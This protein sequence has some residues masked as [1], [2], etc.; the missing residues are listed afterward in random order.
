MNTIKSLIEISRKYGSNPEFVLGGGGN[1]SC[2]DNG[3]L[4][5]KASGFALGTID[6]NGFV[7]LDLKQVLA[8]LE[9][10][11]ST[12]PAQREKQIL[13][14]LQDARLQGKHFGQV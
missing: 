14:A 9:N 2:K 6:E 7:K 5:V 10:T 1:T 8:I 11:F 3:I 12:V 13:D 4:T